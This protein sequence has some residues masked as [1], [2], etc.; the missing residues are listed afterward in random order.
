MRK[1]RQKEQ[2]ELLL[3]VLA[4]TVPVLQK[5]VKLLAVLIAPEV[6]GRL[7]AVAKNCVVELG[8]ITWVINNTFGTENG[9]YRIS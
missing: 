9:N 5:E 1:L 8:P 3:E 6:G 4:E 7:K 2:K